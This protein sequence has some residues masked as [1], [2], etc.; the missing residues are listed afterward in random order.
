MKGLKYLITITKREYSEAYLDFFRRHN[1]SGVISLLCT[2]TANEST[3]NLL[4]LEKTEKVMF[5]A[6]VRNEDFG[7]LVKGLILEMNISSDGNGL[8]AFIPID[9][10]GGS[11]S[12]KYFIGDKTL[13]KKEDDN[14]GVVENNISMIIAI[15]DKGNTELVM[16]A[17]RAAGAGGGTVVRAKGTG[18]EMAKFFGVSIS[19]EKEMVY[20]VARRDNRDAIMKSIMEQAGSNTNAHGVIFA[21]PVDS[22]VGLK[23]FE[24]I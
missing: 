17:A 13:E 9:S 4:G 21:L 14:M 18:A 22:V 7:D 6:M 20:I 12:L 23:C 3:L 1:V 11:S 5:N 10:I 16:N 24:N 15:V 2:G 8:A 19:E